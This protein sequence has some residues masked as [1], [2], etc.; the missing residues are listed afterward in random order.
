MSTPVEK[1][2]PIRTFVFAFRGIAEMLRTERNAR[3]HA[4]ATALV[5]GFGFALGVDRSEWIAL[6]LAIAFVWSAE[7]FNTAF[8]ALCD[9]ASPDYHPQVKRAKDI[10]AGAV[11]LAAI[12][13]ALI[14]ILILGRRIL[15]LMAG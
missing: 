11:L 1:S 4:F 9:V 14:A 12:G 5:I 13:A 7:G 3:I 2:G 6:V 10:A 8:E 15:L